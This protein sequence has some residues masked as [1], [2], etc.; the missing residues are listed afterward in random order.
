MSDRRFGVNGGMAIKVPCRVCAT[1]NITL[2]GEQTIDGVA[3]V[4]GD[5]VLV[6]GQTDGSENG[7]YECDTGTWS[8]TKDW[9]GVYDIVTGTLVYAR[10]GTSD[11]GWYYVAT[12]GAIT[13]GTTSVTISLAGTSL[14][15]TTAFIQTLLNDADAATARATLAALGTDFTLL[16]A[17]TAPDVADLLALYDSSASALR[18]ITPDNFF[19]VINTLSALT[20]PAVADEIVIYDASG[21]ASFKMTLSD[22][23]K[24]INLLT[25]DSAPN[26]FADYVVTYDASATDS[27]KVLLANLARPILHVY[28]E[29]SAGTAGGTATSGSWETRTLNTAATNEITG[30]S[31]AS[32]QITLPAGTY[33]IDARA[34]AFRCGAHKIKLYDTTGTA[35]LLIGAPINSR[36]DENGAATVSFLRGRF[37]LSTESVLEVRH[38]VTTTRATDGYG[39]AAGFSTVERYTDVVITRVS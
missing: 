12:T 13:I 37:T 24:V 7:I 10:S 29:K 34:P 17:L 15:A 6:T 20:A 11:S 26:P 9:D 25:T 32:N 4:D 21:T 23:L 8:R 38:Q 27:R 39:Q 14:V 36:T 18:K 19:K 2:S 31:L 28:D 1:S 30:A 33:Y 5:R 3:V 35:D 16:T 22:V